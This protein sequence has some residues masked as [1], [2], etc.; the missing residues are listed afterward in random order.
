MT[1]KLKAG[2][3][4]TLRATRMSA[5]DFVADSRTLLLAW[6]S[7][8]PDEVFLS[9]GRLLDKAIPLT[10]GER[11]SAGL[12]DARRLRELESGRV[13]AKRALAMIG[14]HGVERPIGPDRSPE[15]PAGAVGS[16]THVM[17]LDGGHFAAAV[18]RED[19]VCAIGI[20]V[21]REDGLHPRLWDHVLTPRE[22]ERVLALPVPARATEA[23]VVWCAKEAVGKAALRPIE[24]VD[25]DIEIDRNG[26]GYT[27][28][29]RH[30]IGGT[31]RSAHVWHGR[32][33]RSQG[34]ILAAV[35]LPNTG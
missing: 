11:A 22:L 31:V 35:V 6:R 2:G 30:A 12:V 29:W 9:A 26:D 7:L 17:G 27:A 3:T 34:F 8:L 28:T 1:D 14:F 18:A 13:Y 10:A 24:P 33:A 16:I 25:L 4:E 23:Q 5:K 21:E 19:A 20:D 32:I 15:W